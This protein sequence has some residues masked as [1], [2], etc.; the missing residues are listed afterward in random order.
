MKFLGDNDATSATQSDEPLSSDQQRRAFFTQP[1]YARAAVVLGGPAANLLFAFL[2]LTGVFFFAGEPYSPATVAVQVDGPA[3]KA[4][5]RTG[6]EIVRLGDKR[7]DRY[8]DIQ[9][10][11]FLYWAK[12]MAVEYRRG[13]QLLNAEIVPQFCERTDNYNNTMRFGELGMDQLMRP[14]VG[15][16]TPNSPAE[17][18]GLKVGDLLLE[19][20]GKPVDHF[21]HI[22]ELIGG[23]AGQPVK[24]KYDRDGKRDETTVVPDADKAPTAPAR[25]RRSAG[26]ASV[27]PASP[28][29]AAMTCSARWAP[30]CAR[31]GA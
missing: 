17:A 15:G 19:I 14:V 26:C 11:Q 31:C 13:N 1:L 22:P 20:D 27:R 25:S 4:G 16:F 7:I 29:S 18:A 2:L 21:T 23:R 10:S 6:D 3:A 24:V 12:P 8:E 5:L 28:S 9:E 30:A